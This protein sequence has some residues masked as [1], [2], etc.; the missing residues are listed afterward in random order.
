MS[1]EPDEHRQAELLA[2]FGRAPIKRIY[3]MSASYAEPGR[4]RFDLPYNP[5]FDHALH[6]VHGGVMATLL[7]NAGWFSVAAHYET[8]VSTAEFQVR[9]L[10]PAVREHL[11][12]IGRVRRAGNRLAV[13]EME[14]RGEDDTLVATGSGTF[15]VT[16][17]PYGAGET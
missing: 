1:H 5:D 8:W 17:I 4:A 12:S 2:L 7:D 3:G 16:D 14:V 13:A 6:Q 11:Y 15:M 10:R 9:L